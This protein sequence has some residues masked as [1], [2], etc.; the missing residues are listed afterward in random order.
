MSSMGIDPLETLL[1]TTTHTQRKF[2]KEELAM[3]N[4][5]H[6]EEKR[7]KARE[8]YQDFLEYMRPHPQQYDDYTKTAYVS[9]PIHKLMVSFWE[10]VEDFTIMRGAMSVPPQTGKTTHTSEDGTAWM[11]GRNPDLH[12]AIG[13]YNETRAK[14]IGDNL[15]A[16][17]TSERYLEVFPE[18][19]LALGGKNKSHLVSEKRGDIRLVGRGS[20]IT[21]RPVDVFIIDDPVKD[22]AEAQSTAALDECWKWFSTTCMQRA[23]N[24]TRYVI[25]HTRWAANDLIGRVCDP[26]HPDYN[27]DI[28]RGY[29]YLNVKAYNNEPHIAKLLGIPAEECIWPEKFS[30][31]LLQGIQKIM[32]PEDFSAL[33]MGKPV[34]DEGGFFQKNMILPYEERD[35]PHRD[36]LK[37]YAASDH[38]LSLKRQG[39]YSVLIIAGV[40]EHGHIWLLDLIRKKMTSDKLV[41]EM[42]KL[43]EYWRPIT[44]WAGKDQISGSIG[45]FLKRQM[46]E[47]GLF[48]THLVDSPEIGDKIAK[49]QP[50]RAMMSL[51]LVHVPSKAIWYQDFVNELLRFRGQGD[52]QDDQVDALAHLG[53]G[54]ENMI[55]SRKIVANDQKSVKVGTL[56]WVMAETAQKRAQ[57]AKIKGRAGW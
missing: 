8:N 14:E 17:L 41:E 15:R 7:L 51:G 46:K 24:L 54:L 16:I 4:L 27:A 55:R 37:I 28:A 32:S 38:A 3:L 19:K 6:K 35:R 29:V 18:V 50:I 21:G 5:I 2:T 42:T 1:S 30:P 11:F 25:I 53:R 48:S 12:I 56:A 23:H 57:E 44:W 39:N 45:P 10:D 40:D 36:R 13:T 34:P 22:K 31:Q 33:Y 49:A 43:M 20:G 26:D 52:A 47:M 9:K